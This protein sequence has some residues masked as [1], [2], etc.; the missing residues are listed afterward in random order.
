VSSDVTADCG[1]DP[2][3]AHRD[4][5]QMTPDQARAV[6]VVNRM[7]EAW[8]AGSLAPHLAQLE[9][10]S[11]V[12]LRQKQEAAREAAARHAESLQQEGTG[13]ESSAEENEVPSEQ[14]TV[15][16]VFEDNGDKV[17]EKATHQGEDDT[18]ASSNAAAATSAPK[19]EG[20]THEKSEEKQEDASTGGEQSATT[21]LNAFFNLAQGEQN[22]AALTASTKYVFP[23]N[24]KKQCAGS[25]SE[26]NHQHAG[27]PLDASPRSTTYCDSASMNSDDP[28]AGEM[29][30]VVEEEQTTVAPLHISSGA[31]A[32]RLSACTTVSLDIEPA[33]STCG[34]CSSVVQDK[35]DSSRLPRI[36]GGSKTVSD[37]A[38]SKMSSVS[39]RASTSASVSRASSIFQ[40]AP[41]TATNAASLSKKVE[42]HAVVDGALEQSKALQLPPVPA[43]V[44][45]SLLDY[46]ADTFS[47][48]SRGP[49]NESI[50]K[51]YKN[52]EESAYWLRFLGGQNIQIQETNLF[53]GPPDSQKVYLEWTYAMEMPAGTQAK[54]ARG[55]SSAKETDGGALSDGESEIHAPSPSSPSEDEGIAETTAGTGKLQRSENGGPVIMQDLIA[56]TVSRRRIEHMRVFFGCPS[57]WDELL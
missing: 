43:E 55:Q 40:P 19:M 56:Y 17:A 7:L 18:V 16:V 29:S 52:L 41:R 25:A 48:D 24:P 31:K 6:R 32:G 1:G 50:F 37:S 49:R 4:C 51:Q 27:S 11:A 36:V 2:A 9:C 57:A 12:Y 3:E 8:V 20:L 46:F 42:Q 45:R 22:Q 14:E 33:S 30:I 39:T 26:K 54:F 13:S 47:C 38:S 44:R 21:S 28:E 5:G 35:Q 34:T 15:R 23:W 10:P 53:P